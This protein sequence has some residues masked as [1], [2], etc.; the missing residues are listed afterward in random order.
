MGA[1]RV[2]WHFGFERN[3]RRR[4]PRSFE[5]RA[6]VQLSSEPS[7][8]DYL[9]LRKLAAAGAG[10]D[11]DAETLRGLWPR[12]PRVSVVEYKSPGRPY[13]P[14]NLDRLWGYVHTY[15]A[16]QRALPRGRADGTA[17][18]PGM[19][20]APEVWTRE[21]LCA[22]LVV[23]GRTL[24]LDEDAASMGLAWEDLGGGYGR[25]RGGLFVLYVV[26][27]DVVGPAEE[28]D[29]LHSLG[30]GKPVTPE[31]RWFWA[32]LV[33]TEEAR[34]SMQDME[35]YDEMVQRFLGTL[36]PEQRLAGLPPEQRLAGL[37]PEQ[38]LAGLPPEQRLAGL[39]P[40]QRLAGLPPEQRLAGLPPEQRLAG[41][42]PEQRLAGLP[43]E[44]RLAGLD[45]DHEALAL[46]VELLR[47]L[48]EA[49]LRSLPPEV[50]AEIRRRRAQGDG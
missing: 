9:L 23:P 26:E 37:P 4:G 11:D 7:R 14:G 28:D 25:L 8:L 35:G 3:L 48:P 40:E 29:L 20:G 31:A 2:I 22:V 44:Q 1:K 17:V 30:N 15:F 33:G 50:E 39:P 45:R 36:S 27:I 42:P 18:A 16:D 12:L 47:F 38:R 21:D 24:G 13:R 5:I 49:Y 34:M 6:E 46:S 41:L 43:P 10:Q 32:E 19:E